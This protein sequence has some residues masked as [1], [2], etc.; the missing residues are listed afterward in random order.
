MKMK[1][2]NMTF[3]NPTTR[4]LVVLSLFL[5]IAIF[6]V[7]ALRAASTTTPHSFRIEKQWNV[8]GKGGWGPLCLDAS[9]RR[10]Y[11][12]RTDRIMVVDTASGEVSGQVDGMTNARDIALDDSGRYGYVT[13]VTD[14]T[15]GFVRVFERSTLKIVTSIPTGL[16]PGAIV[17]DPTTKS[18]FVFNSRGHSA[19]VID[20]TTNQVIATIPLSGRPSSAILDGA[21]SVYVALPALGEITRI[22]TAA[23]KVSAS[24]QLAPCAGPTGLAIDSARRQL[25][26]VCEDHKLVTVSADTGRVAAVADALV[27]SGDINFDSKHNMLFLADA[28]GTLTIFRRNSV[29]RY[30]RLQRVK[31]QSGARSMVVN[32]QDA[33]AYLVSSK[34]GQNTNAVS[35]ELQYRPT[36]IPGTFSVIVVGR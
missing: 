24:W 25:F 32:Q 21:G 19:T 17:F 4:L 28:S 20:S 18:V 34:F 5:A 33:K 9:T 29:N 11:I 23:K 12:P 27:S 2:S 15:A 30:S 22:D 14:G 13:D 3:S 10:L 7:S 8:G 16:I 35:E 26:T 36:P 6:P 31:T 1:N